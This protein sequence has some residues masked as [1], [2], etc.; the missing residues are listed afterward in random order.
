MFNMDKSNLEQAFIRGM[1]KRAMEYG[2][3]K[4]AFL[5]FLLGAGEM[6]G[7]QLLGNWG[8][9]R[10]AGW[11][12]R[13]GLRGR[14]GGLAAKGVSAMQNVP[15]EFKLDGANLA[16]QSAQILPMLAGSA[17]ISPITGAIRNR[18]EPRPV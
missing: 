8:M 2:I 17:A 1:Q 9:Q 15:K 3:E 14:L 18:I 6:I 7:G 4:T 12:G 13:A 16:H 10:L 5:P 11:A